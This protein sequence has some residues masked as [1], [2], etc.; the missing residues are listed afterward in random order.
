SSGRP[1]SGRVD[2]PDEAAAV[3]Q[4]HWDLGGGGVVLAQPVAQE[5]AL[6]PAELDAALAEAERRAAAQDVRG[7]AGTPFLLARLAELTG[8]KTL[9]TN[10]ALIVANARL[11]ARL[12]LALHRMGACWTPGTT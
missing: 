5:A 4:A 7:P 9:R 6:A 8:G 10:Q 11:A 12:A 3:L 1:V 2:G